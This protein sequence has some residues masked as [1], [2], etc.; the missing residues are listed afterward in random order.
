MFLFLGEPPVCPRCPERLCRSQIKFSEELIALSLAPTKE[1]LFKLD[2][3]L[4]EG[5]IRE[6]PSLCIGQVF[7][8][9]LNDCDW[10]VFALR[11]LCGLVGF[12]D[13]AR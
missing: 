2:L 10:R 5:G 11:S 1:L 13:D 4:V 6:L 8:D 12:F 3:Q 7:G 9:G